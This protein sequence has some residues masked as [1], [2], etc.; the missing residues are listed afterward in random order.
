MPVCAFLMKCLKK[1]I[2]GKS[3]SYLQEPSLQKEKG[4][5]CPQDPC[6]EKSRAFSASHHICSSQNPYE[7]SSVSIFQIRRPRLRKVTQ[8]RNVSTS[9]IPAAQSPVPSSQQANTGW[10]DRW[11][12]KRR[13]GKAGLDP[14]PGG[15]DRILWRGPEQRNHEGPGTGATWASEDLDILYPRTLGC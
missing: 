8:S 14:G 2:Q 15:L 6:K 7:V 12:N 1:E 3:W 5:M 4:D 10:R 13:E 11:R 9:F